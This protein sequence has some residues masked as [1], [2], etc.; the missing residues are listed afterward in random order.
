MV[1]I[2]STTFDFVTK[3]KANV[4][5]VNLNE[6]TNETFMENPNS[7]MFSFFCHIFSKYVLLINFIVYLFQKNLFKTL[8]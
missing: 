3:N 8:L 1:V 6:N 5:Y 2:V 4:A 7:S